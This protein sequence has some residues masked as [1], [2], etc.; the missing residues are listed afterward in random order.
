MPTST[1]QE[2][3]KLYA[4]SLQMADLAEEILESRGQ[5]SK[6]FLRSLKRSLADEKAGRVR[7]INSLADLA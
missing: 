7:K 1:P 6:E 4:L 5:Y 2:I 3:H